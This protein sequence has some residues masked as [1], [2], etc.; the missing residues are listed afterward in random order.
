MLN[1][2]LHTI[3]QRLPAQQGPACETATQAGAS[4]TAT[5]AER[6]KMA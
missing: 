2:V 5:G 6:L 1:A 4:K 3:A